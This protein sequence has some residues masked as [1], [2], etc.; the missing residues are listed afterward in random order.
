MAR[1]ALHACLVR[2]WHVGFERTA[3]VL[4]PLPSEY[5]THKTVRARF[6]PDFEGK[7]PYN[8][9]LLPLGSEAEI[10]LPRLKN[11]NVVY[12]TDLPRFRGRCAPLSNEYGTYK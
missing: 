2:W 9:K 8:V 7:N 11:A 12:E 5:G 1:S 10:D 4:R 6:W 3:R